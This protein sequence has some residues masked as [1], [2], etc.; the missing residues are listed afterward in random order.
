MLKELFTNQLTLGCAQAAVATLLALAV[1]LWPGSGRF[2]SSARPSSRWFAGLC[3]SLRS[4]R[5]WCFC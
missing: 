4:D 3:R 2:T 1:M 5:S